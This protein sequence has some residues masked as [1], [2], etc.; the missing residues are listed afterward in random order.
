[1]GEIMSICE[2]PR[3]FGFPTAMGPISE[4][5]TKDPSRIPR[6]LHY[7]SIPS[8]STR[9]TKRNVT[10]GQPDPIN[11]MENST[12][13]VASNCENNGETRRQSVQTS[14]IRGTKNL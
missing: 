9:H 6:Q 2:D 14:L 3:L 12:D 10:P 13:K 7:E 8:I 1:M 5:E 4:Y 11:E